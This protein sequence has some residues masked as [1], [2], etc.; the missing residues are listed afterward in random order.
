MPS[1][2]STQ[3]SNPAL[4]LNENSSAIALHSSIVIGK[5]NCSGA[6]VFIACTTAQTDQQTSVFLIPCDTD[7]SK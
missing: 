3:L 7:M 4:L 1:M 6:H 2:H 5:Q